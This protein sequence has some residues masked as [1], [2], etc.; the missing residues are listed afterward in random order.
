M[1]KFFVELS[2]EDSE[3]AE[4]LHELEEA[5][6]TIY[7]CYERLRDMDVVVLRGANETP[8]AATDGAGITGSQS[9]RKAGVRNDA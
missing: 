4:V 5:R 2:I 1:K 9:R 7:R 3:L 8:S 6:E